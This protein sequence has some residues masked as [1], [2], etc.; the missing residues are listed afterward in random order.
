[1]SSARRRIIPVFIPNLGCEHE[2]VFCDQR[3]ISGE[4]E[5]VTPEDVSNV[6]S[7]ALIALAD[8]GESSAAAEVAFYGGSFTA[9]SERRQNEL[10][11][12]VQPFLKHNARNSIRISTRPDCMDRQAA[13]RLKSFGVGT[14]EL[15]AQSMCGD[16]L[17]L[18]K[19]G[20]TAGDVARASGI[21]KSAGLCLILQ[22]MTGLPGDSREKSLYTAKHIIGLKPDGVRIYPAV[23]VRGTR[24]FEMWRDGSYAEHTVEEA[25]GLCAELCALFDEAGIPVIRL[26]LNPT[27]TLSAGGA[28][29]GAYHPAFGELVYSKIYFE[30]AVS[31]LTGVR[32]GSG[33]VI[34]VARG[35]V[36]KMAG[37]RRGNIHALIEKFSLGS[38]K[39][40]ESDIVSC[41]IKIEIEA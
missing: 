10:L 40:V 37:H 31:A 14:V 7:E 25:V 34:T 15:G 35:R 39:I 19:R 16:V 32:P 30:K 26:G 13:L 17:A 4:R 20:H 9:L 8:A 36:S 24:L 11:E 1:M 12:A 28:A 23:V 18:S 38:L 29:A 27:D 22:M 6:C 2:C 3:L 5:P 41:E 21:I 33:V